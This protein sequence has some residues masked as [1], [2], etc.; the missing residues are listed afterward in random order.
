MLLTIQ[1]L[2][3][4]LR[5]L[6]LPPFKTNF[7]SKADGPR[8]KGASRKPDGH[9]GII[10]V[11]R[12]QPDAPLLGHSLI[13][14]VACKIFYRSLTTPSATT[15]RVISLRSGQDVTLE[16]NFWG[17]ATDRTAS[18][19]F[20]KS[21]SGKGRG[22]NLKDDNSWRIRIGNPYKSL[23]EGSEHNPLKRRIWTEE[24]F[25]IEKVIGKIYPFPLL[26]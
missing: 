18:N 2:T 7:E 5:T 23:G 4:F 25:Y 16:A 15:S 19:R 9:L 17:P 20:W 13:S 26:V 3:I 10:C 12:W 14:F 1:G 21:I 6:R 24:K 8:S 22:T 11:W